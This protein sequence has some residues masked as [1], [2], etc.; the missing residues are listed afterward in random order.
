MDMYRAFLAIVLSFVILFGYQ[1]FFAPPVQQQVEP[2]TPVQHD[3]GRVVQPPALAVAQPLV[4]PDGIL[5]PEA[6]PARDIIVETPLYSLVIDE[7]GG[8]IKHFILKEYRTVNHI[9]APYMELITEEIAN[10]LPMRFSLDNGVGAE[11]LLFRADRES[12]NVHEGQGQ[13]MLTMT[14]VLSSGLEIVRSMI[15]HADSYLI[16]INYQVINRGDSQVTIAPAM[17][18][19]G[20]PFTVERRN[21]MAVGLF[22]GLSAFVNNELFEIS[23]NKLAD[24]PDVF[25]GQ[26][27]WV[28]YGDRYFIKAMVPLNPGPHIVTISGSDEQITAVMSEEVVALAPGARIEY[29]YKMYFG[30][31]KFSILEEVGH[32]LSKAVNFGWFDI[33]AKPMHWMLNVFY[34]IF[35]N[36]GIAIILVTVLVKLLFWPITQKGLKSMKNMQ[37]LQPKVAKL[38]EKYKGDPA[39]MNQEMMAMYKT[40]KVNP[41]GGCLPMLL[42]IPV[43][44]ALYKVLLTA[45]E[46]RHAPFM[47]WINDLAAPDR[48]MIGFEIPYLQGIPVLTLL[49]GASMYFQMKLTP[50]TA[51]PLQAKIMQFLPIIFTFLFLNFAA[52]LVLYWFVNN[53]L[54]ILQQQLI[55]RKYATEINSS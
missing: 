3:P 1:F 38:R 53:L 49:M 16:S 23:P 8:G 54:S 40:Y 34:A 55:N 45:I 26:V 32:N 28:G 47:L 10:N 41:L 27:D 14:A 39:K 29:N 9:N 35:G 11:V 52:G 42:Q 15:F 6:Q 21:P 5:I 18:L 2:Q 30:P 48:L 46:L 43:F 13:E 37:K 25:Q 20:S 7:R 4:S 17:T 36:Y 50:T 44:F 12:I 51:D 22:V 33:I 24:G 31:K 19:T